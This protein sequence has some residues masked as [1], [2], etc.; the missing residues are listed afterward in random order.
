[1]RDFLSPQEICGNEAALMTPKQT[2]NL[3]RRTA[4][5]EAVSYLALLGIAMPLKYVWGI[6]LAVKVIGSVHGALFV[7]FCLTLALAMRAARWS[8]GR[9]VM[10]FIAS[11]IPLLPFWLDARVRTWVEEAA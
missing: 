9:G 5:A 8:L 1:V 2:V 10:L 7:A 3:F 4:L 6:P 11:L